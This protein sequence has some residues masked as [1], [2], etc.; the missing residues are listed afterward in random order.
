MTD[1]VAY[2]FK[3]VLSVNNDLAVQAISSWDNVNKT[4]IVYAYCNGSTPSN[5]TIGISIPTGSHGTYGVQICISFLNNI[6]TMY[7]RSWNDTTWGS[8]NQCESQV[9]S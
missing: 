2:T 5:Y 3:Y 6:G 8:W 4:K 9:V 1:Y 7:S